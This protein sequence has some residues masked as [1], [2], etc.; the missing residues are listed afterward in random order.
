M[1]AAHDASVDFLGCRIVARLA[2]VSLVSAAPGLIFAWTKFAGA[3]GAG[4]RIQQF[5]LKQIDSVRIEADMYFDMNQT[6]NDLGIFMTNI[7]G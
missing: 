6:S 5:P 1:T 3:S 7:L 2:F 4:T